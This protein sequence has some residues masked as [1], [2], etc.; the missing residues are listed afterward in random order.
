MDKNNLN[1]SR[2]NFLKITSTL[3]VS[4]S[5]SH[6]ILL[7]NSNGITIDDLLTD[8]TIPT[9]PSAFPKTLVHK[10][11]VQLDSNGDNL[12]VCVRKASEEPVSADVG[13]PDGINANIVTQYK[14]NGS[15]D[16]YL[17]L[18]G[19]PDNNSSDD[20]QVCFW[21]KGTVAI[22]NPNQSLTPTKYS[23]KLNG[24]NPSNLST[25]FK[26][27][28]P[29]KGNQEFVVYN[30]RGEQIF[31]TKVYEQEGIIHFDGQNF[32]SGIYL[33]K[34]GNKTVNFTIQK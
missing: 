16:V 32:S 10:Y 6:R 15:Y 24:P 23:L 29:S 27:E 21:D 31:S 19:E 9:N 3:I 28:I 20:I 8:S 1:N 13:L 17:F 4:I 33:A 2:R 12:D 25:S 34:L 5:I 22:D 11:G 30:L 7:G 18:S 14:G 26:Y